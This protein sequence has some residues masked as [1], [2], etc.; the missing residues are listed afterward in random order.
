MGD[1]LDPSTDR[2][3]WVNLVE[4][5]KSDN[6]FGLAFKEDYEFLMVDGR[7]RVSNEPDLVWR[8]RYHFRLTETGN[9]AYESDITYT[10]PG[11]A[12]SP[13]WLTLDPADDVFY[14]L[15]EGNQTPNG[16][17]TAFKTSPD[18][19]LTVLSDHETITG[20]VSSVLYGEESSRA[21]ALAHYGGHAVSTF[22][23]AASNSFV[24]LQNITIALEKRGPNPDRQSAAFEHQMILDPTGQNILGPDLG[25][26]LVRVLSI[27]PS[28]N[29]LSEQAAPQMPAGSGPRHAVFWSSNG[30]VTKGYRKNSTL[31]LYVVTELTNTIHGFQV[32]YPA[33]GGMDFIPVSS[34]NTFGGANVP[35]GAAAAEVSVSPDNRFVLVSN[36]LDKTF[37]FRNPD[38]TN[39]T[40]EAS[41][42]LAN[43][44][45]Q[46]NG[47]LLF[48]QLCPAGGLH[49]RYFSFNKAGDLVAVALQLSDRVV[50]HMR[51]VDTGYF[52]WAVAAHWIEG[53]PTTVVWDE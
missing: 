24:P 39:S 8:Q 42:S 52:Q 33:A 2:P 9:G 1:I 11:C 10:N 48:T 6:D 3:L 7:I 40:A 46:P 37:E 20:Q 29:L 5:L 21:I 12:G 50:I 4:V 13:S 22:S 49:P 31:F 26:D 16:S 51:D 44:V 53:Q 47:T 45:P 27:D 30:D 38:P 15:D 41:D 17:V 14:C 23:V 18:G 19:E 35:Q 32:A 25:A 36:R 28:T 43:F 34:I